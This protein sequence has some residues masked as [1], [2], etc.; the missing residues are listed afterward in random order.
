MSS[1]LGLS[2]RVLRIPR[3]DDPESYVLVHITRTSSS[4]VDLNIIATEGENPYIGTGAPIS[5]FFWTHLLFNELS[6]S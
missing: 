2:P 5:Y 4:L 3:T 1:E 6:K